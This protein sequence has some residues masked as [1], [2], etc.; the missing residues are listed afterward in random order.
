M[1]GTHEN[2][3]VACLI[4]LRLKFLNPTIL[5]D[6]RMDLDKVVLNP[7]IRSQT[8]SYLSSISIEK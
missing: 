4:L 1:F 5:V 7:V 8:Y 2:I 3:L 6:L